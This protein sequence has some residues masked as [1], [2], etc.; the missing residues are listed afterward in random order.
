MAGA[1]LAAKNEK[2]FVLFEDLFC[3]NVGLYE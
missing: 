3:F 1:V 2:V